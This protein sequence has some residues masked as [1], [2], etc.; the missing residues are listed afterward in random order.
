MLEL[1]KDMCP[2]TK[3]VLN[4]NAGKMRVQVNRKMKL[5]AKEKITDAPPSSQSAPQEAMM[6]PFIKDSI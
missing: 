6:Y 4:P 2:N 5:W 1:S 3:N